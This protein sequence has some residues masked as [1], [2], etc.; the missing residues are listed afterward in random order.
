MVMLLGHDRCK[1][2]SAIVKHATYVDIGLCA[3]MV[4]QCTTHGSAI[5]RSST[6]APFEGRQ[7]AGLQTVPG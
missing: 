2:T 5:A 4:N 7:S 1:W 3:L 6:Y